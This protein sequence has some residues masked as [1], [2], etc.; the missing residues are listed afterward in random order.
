MNVILAYGC[1]IIFLSI[2]RIK[3]ICFQLKYI[4]QGYF[5]Y[6]TLDVVKAEILNTMAIAYTLLLSPDSCSSSV[7]NFKGERMND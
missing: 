1:T 7:F 2:P 4:F 5:K 3:N 6:K